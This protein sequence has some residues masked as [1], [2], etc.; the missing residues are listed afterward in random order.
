M[1]KYETTG[2][3][4]T[5]QIKQK[6]PHILNSLLFPAGYTISEPSGSALP[7]DC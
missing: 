5:Q 7:S 4:L 6:H 3:N 2:K 1:K